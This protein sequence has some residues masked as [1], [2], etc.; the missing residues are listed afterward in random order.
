V[1]ALAEAGFADVAVTYEKTPIAVV[2]AG[3]Q[4]S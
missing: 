2:V 4:K 1:Q 3:P